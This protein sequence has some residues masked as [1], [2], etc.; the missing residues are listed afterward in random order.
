[1]IG[2]NWKMLVHGGDNIVVKFSNKG[3]DGEEIAAV[4]HPKFR[5]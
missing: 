5:F 4:H 3:K 2:K 1:M